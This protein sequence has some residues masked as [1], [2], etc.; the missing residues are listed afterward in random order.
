MSLTSSKPFSSFWFEMMDFQKLLDVAKLS[1]ESFT[2]PMKFSDGTYSFH[3]P[4]KSAILNRLSQ[5][6]SH[7]KTIFYQANFPLKDVWPEYK[8]ELSSVLILCGEHRIQSD[9]NTHQIVCD[10]ADLLNLVLTSLGE[11]LSHL[12]SFSDLA[13][14]IIDRLKTKL[15]SSCYVEYP[16]AVECFHWITA[17]NIVPSVEY[18][19]ASALPISLNLLNSG[20]ENS[21]QQKG[22][23]CIYL[24]L[25]RSSLQ[26]LHYLGW[27]G[28][29]YDALKG[30]YCKDNVTDT[31]KLYKSLHICYTTLYPI[32]SNPSY[33][34]NKVWWN[35]SS[36]IEMAA[37]NYLSAE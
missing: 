25:S 20:F 3:G 11:N 27:T 2:P 5:N 35:K 8:K 37:D 17:N 32:T 14:S 18:Y 21:Y 6:V 19:A 12:L 10:V 16:A 30:L 1:D 13:C 36:G 24:I 29:I 9:W 28:V 31:I 23:D 15:K 7:L 33:M 34:K 22:L 4:D 26:S